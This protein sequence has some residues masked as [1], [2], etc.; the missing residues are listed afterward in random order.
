MSDVNKDLRLAQAAFQ[1]R[2]VA[3]A[4]HDFQNHLAVIKEYNGLMRDLLQT[5][6]KA[7]EFTRRSKEITGH[8]EDRAKQAAALADMLNRFAHRSDTA[9]SRFRIDEAVEELV[10]LL[11]R[12]ASQKCV[13][14]EATDGDGIQLIN[15][16]SLFQFLLFS[17]IK[18]FLEML[19]GDGKVT[20]SA[21]V[22]GEGNAIIRILAQGAGLAAGEHTLIEPGPLA[23]CVSRLRV[24]VSAAAIDDG[25]HEAVLLIPDLYHYQ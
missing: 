15:D 3:G 12:Y 25:L 18:H 16:P 13:K 21:K 11:Q 19:E 4:T 20:I 23:D 1:G 17:F 6:M 2:I 10:A 9:T 5:K 8:V 24:T 14:L 22:E 7:R